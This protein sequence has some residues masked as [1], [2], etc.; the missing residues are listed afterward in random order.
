MNANLESHYLTCYT[1]TKKYYTG[2]GILRTHELT[3]VSIIIMGV[4]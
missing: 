2:R 3:L 4:T 1:N